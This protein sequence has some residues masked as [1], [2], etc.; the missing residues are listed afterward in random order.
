[1]YEVPSPPTLSPDRVEE[2]L[3]R[4]AEIQFLGLLEQ[5]DSQQRLFE[6]GQGLGT[7]LE[8][9]VDVAARG[10]VRSAFGHRGPAFFLPLPI[11]VICAGHHEVLA[12]VALAIEGAIVTTD[13][14]FECAQAVLGRDGSEVDQL[15]Q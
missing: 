5:P 11:A 10:L 9:S 13:D 15:D 6:A 8:R 3:V 12:R 14:G 4:T 7:F 2:V 1:M